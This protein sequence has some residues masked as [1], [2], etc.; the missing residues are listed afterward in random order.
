MTAVVILSVVLALLVAGFVAFFLYSRT[1]AWG[2]SEVR[3]SALRTLMIVGPIFG[4]HYKAP[5]PVPPAV[6]TPG[7]EEDGL[8]SPQEP[9]ERPRSR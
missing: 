9:L 8:E 7:G 1:L 2:E 3:K 5:R 6:T 4:M